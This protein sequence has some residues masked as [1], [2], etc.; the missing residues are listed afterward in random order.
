VL[1]TADGKAVTVARGSADLPFAIDSPPA[2]AQPK[3]DAALA[4]PTG[5]LEALTLDDVKP[6]AELPI[7][8]DG[9]A[10]AAFTAFDGLIV[11]LRLSSPDA[12]N[13]IALDVTG[14]GK[15]EAEA[16]ALD[17]R[18]S[19]WSFAISPARAKLLRTTL[20]D[21]LQPHGS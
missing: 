3:D 12:G 20:P 2:D 1:T 16:K 5:A 14:A 17:A 19:H 15:S 21:L 18:L 13:W 8:D 7:P 9:V 11:G 10:T 6:A 4:A